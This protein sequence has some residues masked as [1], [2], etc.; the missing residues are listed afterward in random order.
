[1]KSARYGLILLILFFTALSSTSV[2]SENDSETAL[3]TPDLGTIIVESG[4]LEWDM[5]GK[6]IV[7]DEEVI[8][9]GEGWTMEC[10]KLFVY[11]NDGSAEDG[12]QDADRIDRI[13]AKGKVKIIRPDGEGTAEEALYDLIEQKVVLTGQPV[14]KRGN[15]SLAGSKIILFKDKEHLKVEGPIRAVLHPKSEEGALSSGQ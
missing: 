15:E 12:S 13:I 2:R 1:M 4:S 5:K 6:T 14:F 10:D 8:A 7:F 11:L 3:Q 9:Q